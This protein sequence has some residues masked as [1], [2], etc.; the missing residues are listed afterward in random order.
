MGV[1]RWGCGSV[2]FCNWLDE[3]IKEELFQ[4]AITEQRRL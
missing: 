4:R 2:T 3:S 1:M